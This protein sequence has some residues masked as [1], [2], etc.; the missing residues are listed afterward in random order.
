MSPTARTTSGHH[1]STRRIESDRIVLRRSANRP[2]QQ[3]LQHCPLL[4]CEIPRPMNRDHS[5]FKIHFRYTELF[6]T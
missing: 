1:T 3:R 4:V 5:P 2:V 6:P